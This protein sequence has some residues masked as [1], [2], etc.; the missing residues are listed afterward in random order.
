MKT[1]FLI[2]A[3]L[4]FPPAS[5][6]S[7]ETQD[8]AAARQL[9]EEN[10]AAIHDRDLDAYL[11]CY[12]ESEELVR[13]GAAGPRLGFDE[14]AAGAGRGP[15]P[16]R[17]EALDLRLVRIRPGVVFGTYRYRVRYGEREETGVSERLFVDTGD[18]WRI[19]VTSAFASPP[20]TPP[21]PRALVGATLIDGTGAAPVADAV[22]VIRE[23][24][25]ACA[26][27]RA[28]CPVPE[29]AG[30]ADV[31]GHWITPGLIDVHVHLAATGW[32]DA[33]PGIADLGDE[34]PYPEV[35]AG[36]R[37]RPERWYRALL[38]SGVTAVFDVGGYSWLVDH[39]EQARGSLLAP[40]LAV[41]GPLL[42]TFD[43]PVR[44]GAESMTIY[45]EDAGVARHGVHAL[46]A[47]GTDAVKLWFVPG[48]RDFD[49]LEAVVRALGEEAA[50]R[51]LPI[52]AH[53]TGIREARIALDAG[54]RVLLHSVMDAE[55]DGDTVRKIA[56]RGVVYVPTL[57]VPRAIERLGAA[58]ASGEEPEVDDPNGCVDPGTVARIASTPRYRSLETAGDDL[59]S[60]FVGEEAAGHAAANLQR[61]A[62]AGATIAVGTDAGSPMIV[63][64][65]SIYGEM[66][67]M[68]EAGLS[69]M[70]VLVAATRGGARAMGREDEIGTVTPGRVADL[71]VVAADPA[72][73]VAHL[74]QLRFVVRGGELRSIEELRARPVGLG[75][76]DGMK[77]EISPAE[78]P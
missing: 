14:L 32:I 73:D 25:V 44:V 5:F 21:P 52:V 7:S 26:G 1:P 50:A 31:S 28:A 15:W 9:F 12:L 64:G 23:G 41:T 27:D 4:A 76:G 29:D 45:L 13:V 60:D 34:H 39:R 63:H 56:D 22:V 62:A 72:A 48:K 18:G 69:P 16:D 66:E 74:R 40:H 33:F 2:L 35:V 36:L 78:T 24:R 70:E 51:K 46:D 65:P 42:A 38:C 6:A 57:T 11:A 77:I 58:F 10:L 8:L 55:L 49:E 30:V 67:A 71:L 61:L 20:G 75:V 43:L 54:A 59:A 3:V 68:Q 19:A 17:L 53:A 37:A 47:L